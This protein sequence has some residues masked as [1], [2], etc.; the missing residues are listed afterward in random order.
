MWEKPKKNK[1]I[2]II[3]STDYGSLKTNKMFYFNCLLGLITTDATCASEIRSRVAVTTPAF[4]KEL[5]SNLRRILMTCY[6]WS[7]ALL[8]LTP[9]NLVLK[10]P[11]F[12]TIYW[13]RLD[14]LKCDSG[15]CGE[16]QLN[17]S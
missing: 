9:E 3:P 14:I 17:R 7:A 15:E 4:N 16:D 11:S 6:I 8:A 1:S 5:D 2:K 10:F 13:K 12:I